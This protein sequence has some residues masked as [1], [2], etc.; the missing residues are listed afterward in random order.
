MTDDAGTGALDTFLGEA[1]NVI[2]A[3]LRSDGRPMMTPNWFWWDGERFYVSTTRDRAKYRQFTRDPR[4]QLVI[5]DSLAYR[6][7]AVDGTVEIW[8]E[9]ERVAPFVRLIR[10]KH[11][12][13]MPSDD[14][15]FL[16]EL[17]DEDR[18][19]LAITPDRPPTE[20]R[21]LGL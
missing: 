3:A 12:K 1:R 13:A 19:L 10:D 8:E 11:G 14:Q 18:V 6:S 4:V 21:T 15:Q 17:R 16:A 7:V 5:D 2:V 20:W 9:I